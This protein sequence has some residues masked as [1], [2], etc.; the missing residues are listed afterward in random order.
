METLSTQL[1]GG[2]EAMVSNM[3]ECGSII[4]EKN[5]NFSKTKVRISVY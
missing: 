1:Q 2:K 4:F 3:C 5:Y